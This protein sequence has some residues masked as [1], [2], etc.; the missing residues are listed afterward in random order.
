MIP[1]LTFSMWGNKN[2][3]P[4]CMPVPKPIE[5]R[6]P[7]PTHQ[8]TYCANSSPVS[9]SALLFPAC[10]RCMKSM[11]VPS[12]VSCTDL[13][14]AGIWSNFWVCQRIY[15]W[16]KPLFWKAWEAVFE[17]ARLLLL[18]PM[19]VINAYKHWRD[20]NYFTQRILQFSAQGRSVSLPSCEVYGQCIFQRG[21]EYSLCFS[22]LLQRFQTLWRRNRGRVK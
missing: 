20:T 11:V 9:S 7:K 16:K 19:F 21:R 14:A 10:Q 12:C 17:L 2:S 15:Y 6:M 22:N 18:L 13:S 8:T 5:E 3:S 1:K 4:E